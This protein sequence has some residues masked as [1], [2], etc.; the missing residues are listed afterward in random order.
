MRTELR[1]EWYISKV[2]G[3]RDLAN[4]LWSH[5]AKVSWRGCQRE[6]EKLESLYRTIGKESGRG[7]IRRGKNKRRLLLI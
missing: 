1:T 4:S 7:S 3:I 2:K 5:R 6:W